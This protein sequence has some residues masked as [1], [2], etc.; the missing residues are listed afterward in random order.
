MK[1]IL[2]IMMLSIKILIYLCFVVCFTLPI[3]ASET[4]TEALHEAEV[5]LEEAILNSIRIDFNIYNKNEDFIIS[6]VT[7]DGHKLCSGRI[8][9]K[10][11]NEIDCH[12]DPEILQRPEILVLTTCYGTISKEIVSQKTT[13]FRNPH[14]TK[15]ARRTTFSPS[16][17]ISTVIQGCKDRKI[18]MFATL[19][20]TGGLT[21][22]F[23]S[24][25]H[26]T[27][28]PVTNMKTAQPIKKVVPPPPVVKKASPPP[29]KKVTPPPPVI[30]KS[31]PPPVIKKST[32]QQVP[33]LKPIEVQQI[34][35][36]P[37]PPK[38][39]PEVQKK[40]Q[41]PATPKKVPKPQQ[42]PQTP[43]NKKSNVP[44]KIK[45][46]FSAVAT[47]VI[48]KPPQMPP[49]RV[50]VVKP[51]PPK[52]S[53]S[54]TNIFSFF[55]S[56]KSTTVNVKAKPKPQKQANTMTH[57]QHLNQQ[58]QTATTKPKWIR[59]LAFFAGCGLFIAALT[60][61][62]GSSGQPIGQSFFNFEQTRVAPTRPPFQFP[63][64]R[65]PTIHF[66]VIVNPFPI[67]AEVAQLWMDNT[68][69]AFA[70]ID[71]QQKKKVWTS[72]VILLIQ[73]AFI[74]V[75]RTADVRVFGMNAG[76]AMQ[77]MDYLVPFRY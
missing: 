13:R 34:K 52:P 11:A 77:P 43:D 65:L 66:P 51:M 15:L 56:G 70:Q 75:K 9:K 28:P 31:S 38:K 42:K 16:K 22:I 62:G 63:R 3:I 4:A 69:V 29:A 54:S 47:T 36:P 64:I 20:L 17:A 23:T 19:M 24:P 10:L 49:P 58:Q 21:Y 67:M 46:E 39:S 41:Q 68:R 33:V 27:S 30:K 40:P 74:A 35:K 26:A 57:S 59:T 7:D 37:A 73:A 72:T 60:H 25:E 8:S 1:K 48:K 32:P 71:E 14:G 50:A 12:F 5:A 2:R 6:I 61:G 55:S 53:S 18:I 76:R 44:P 45:K